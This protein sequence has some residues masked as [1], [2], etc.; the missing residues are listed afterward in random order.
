MVDE[1]GFKRNEEMV[2]NA[3]RVLAFY[4]GF[5]SG[6]S[7]TVRMAQEVGLEVHEFIGI[8]KSWKKNKTLLRMISMTMMS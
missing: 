1:D 2:R 8:L 4:D 7:H 6:T 5:S 3:D